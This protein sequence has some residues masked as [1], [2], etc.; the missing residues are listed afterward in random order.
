[1][2]IQEYKSRPDQRWPEGT[3]LGQPG[4]QG[5]LFVLIVNDALSSPNPL[6]LFPNRF[7]RGW[8]RGHQCILL[9]PTSLATD[10]SKITLA[11]SSGL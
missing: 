2:L 6:G 5:E 4:D 7:W 3:A 11:P 9:N 1:M 8:E 10:A